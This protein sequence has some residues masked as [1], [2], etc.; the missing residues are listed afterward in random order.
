MVDYMSSLFCGQLDITVHQV[1]PTPVWFDR[2]SCMT[3]GDSTNTD[4]SPPFV[5][6]SNPSMPLAVLLAIM[7]L[8]LLLCQLQL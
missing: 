4:R 2:N 3:R 7:I 5:L 8:L 1:G 6:F